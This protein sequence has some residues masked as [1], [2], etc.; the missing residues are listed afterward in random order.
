MRDNIVIRD[1][2]RVPKTRRNKDAPDAEVVSVRYMSS[3]LSEAFGSF[4]KL[5]PGFPH[6]QRVFEKHR[7]LEVRCFTL[8]MR[9]RCTCKVHTNVAFKLDAANKVFNNRTHT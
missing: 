1:G 3:T 5:H 9:S 6:S 7:P 4:R 8:R 2:K